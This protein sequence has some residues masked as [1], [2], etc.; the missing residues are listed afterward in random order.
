MIPTTIKDLFKFIDFLHANIENFNKHDKLI[1]ELE[2]LKKKRSEAK[3]VDSFKN[4]LEYE[5]I[6]KELSLKFD[7]LKKQVNNKIITKAKQYNIKQDF[8][9]INLSYED[10]Q[11]LKDK[12][13]FED[14]ETINECKY[15]YLTYRLKTN[16]ENYF[17]F[18]F[19]FNDLDRYLFELFDYFSEDKTGLEI[20]QNE[21]ARSETI[22]EASLY[23]TK[24]VYPRATIKIILDSVLSKIRIR[25][26][27]NKPINFES[28]KASI[29]EAFTMAE[30]LQPVLTKDE[31]KGVLDY[32]ANWITKTQSEVNNVKSKSFLS[33]LIEDFKSID[34]DLKMFEN[35]HF[36]TMATTKERVHKRIAIEAFFKVLKEVSDPKTTYKG[37]II[38][39]ANWNELKDLFFEQRMKAYENSLNSSEKIKLENELL[40]QLKNESESILKG[41]KKQQF[42]TLVDRYKRLLKIPTKEEIKNKPTFEDFFINTT[43][44]QAE[45]LKEFIKPLKGKD[46]AMFI[47]LAFNDFEI[48]NLK[49]NSKDGFN[50]K[51]FIEIQNKN[52]ASVN[53]YLLA[54][55]KFNGNSKDLTSL[56]KQLSTI[57]KNS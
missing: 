19:F 23:L 55:N 52:Y 14:L 22:K 10:L 20:L 57:L 1:N 16:K 6:Q 8:I 43:P 46:L 40:D 45:R 31:N 53:K 26:H 17:A 3:K 7:K 12:A 41:T 33:G 4:R 36:T 5:K 49:S 37:I 32:L 30:K 47:N 48:L 51:T 35:K 42:N 28:L 11:S 39:T 13:T 50:Q 38:N 15:K 18:D 56:E 24:G 27:A 9:D 54:N 34:L 29:I 21:N 25:K 2:V 44:E